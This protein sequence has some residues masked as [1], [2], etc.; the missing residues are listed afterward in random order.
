MK[1]DY[2]IMPKPTGL[3]AVKNLA[4][5]FEHYNEWHPALGYL[6]I[7]RHGNICGD[8]PVMELSDKK[9][10][11]NIGANPINSRFAGLL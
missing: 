5:A 7:V 1:R 2:I 3:T 11:G 8:E 9:M 10:Y 6:G 4:E